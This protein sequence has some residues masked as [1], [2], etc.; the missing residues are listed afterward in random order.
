MA[1]PKIESETRQHEHEFE[2]SASPEEVWRAITDAAELVNWFPLDAEVQPGPDGQITYGWGE[3]FKGSSRIL[4]WEPPSH[5]KT[6]WMN[7]IGPADEH[8]QQVVV[9]WFLEGERGRTR[10]RLVHSGF[11]PGQ[12]WDQEY[13]GT[14]RG[15]AFELY[16]LKNYL[17][18]HRGRQ[19]QAFWLTKPVPMNDAEV[20]KRL[21]GPTGLV[22]WPD[23]TAARKGDSIKLE[24]ATGDRIEG[25]VL[26]YLPPVELACTADNLNHGLFRIGYEDCG[27]GPVANIWVSVWNYP[28]AQFA[29]LKERLNQHLERALI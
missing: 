6:A 2:I 27:S 10:L 21:I 13:E 3:A 26:H 20:W 17:E 16:S 14:R 29:A 5:L 15:W 19:R 4:I 25:R 12:E 9:D 23:S 7:D 11:G 22:R 28:E 24:L 1:T 8:R 18:Q